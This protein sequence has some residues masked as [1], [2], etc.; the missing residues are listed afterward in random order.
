L[1]CGDV[2]MSYRRGGWWVRLQV[3]GC[4]SVARSVCPV[5]MFVDGNHKALTCGVIA[6]NV[7]VVGATEPVVRGVEELPEHHGVRFAGEVPRRV[8]CEVAGGSSLAEPWYD[9]PLVVAMRFRI[10]RMQPCRCWRMRCTL[11]RS[12]ASRGGTAALRL[13]VLLREVSSYQSVAASPS[14]R[15]CVLPGAAPHVPSA[16]ADWSAYDV[17]TLRRFPP[18]L[19]PVPGRR[20]LARRVSGLARMTAMGGV[21]PDW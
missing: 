10:A 15:W 5:G 16:N 11:K 12:F 3:L 9:S 4:V 19:V 14:A 1:L 13:C 18:S 7:G 21:H 6:S 17:G 20:S 2:R 8:P